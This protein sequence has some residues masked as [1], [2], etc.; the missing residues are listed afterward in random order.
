[1]LHKNNDTLMY[2]INEIDESIQG[3]SHNMKVIKKGKLCLKL[4]Q[5]DGSEFENIYCLKIL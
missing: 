4:K 2:G 5:V 3:S 1:M